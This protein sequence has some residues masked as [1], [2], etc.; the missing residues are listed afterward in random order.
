MLLN[1][2]SL[3]ENKNNWEEKNINLPKF[4]LEDVCKN[5]KENP[6]WLH[7]GSGNIFRGYVAD[8]CQDLLNENIINTGIVAVE[9]FDYE[10][11]E[12]TY[13][14]F[15]NLTLL[16]LMKSSGELEKKV[17]ASVCET[18]TTDCSTNDVERLKEIF[19]KENLQMVSFTI[20]EKA[21]AV[22]T[23]DGNFLEIVKSDIENKLASPKHSIS[24]LVS[25]LY[26]R[27]KANKLKLA[28]VS[29]DNCSNNGDKLKNSVLTVANELVNNGTLDKQFIDYLEDENYITFP[30]SMI[31]KI[32]PRPSEEV[33][34]S[35]EQDG[36][37]NVSP[38]KTSKNTFI[39]PFVNAEVAKY[40]VIEDKFPNGRPPLE[41][42]GVYMTNR[43]TVIKTETMKVTTCLN[44]LHT[45]LAIYGCVLSYNS[46][47][48]EMKD[49]EL[50]NL[51]KKMAYDEA[52]PVVVSPKILN[53]E[54]F[55][56]EVIEERLPNPFIPDAP[57]RI[58]TDTSQKVGIR[59]G[60]TLKAYVKNDNLNVE[61]LTY[62]PLVIAGWFR[63]LLAIDD[64]GNKFE[65]SQDPMLN[66]LTSALDGIKIGDKSSYK[67]NLR[68][69]LSNEKLFGVDFIKIGLADKI[70]NIFLELIEGK[71]SVRN[72]LKKYV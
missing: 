48:E 69:F 28:L 53:P 16:A 37:E 23:L 32:T 57:Q 13:R 26:E 31:D 19:R 40:L 55:V 44:P 54:D 1:Y 52:M 3:S 36:I 59:Y 51:I 45:A 29:M 6:T 25:M 33:A 34:K 38:I 7:F 8:L 5:T 20:T 64:N 11:I 63:Y 15:D 2:A 35:F 46:I 41:K 4:N 30:L 12:K 70:E 58:A 61:N 27:F 56:K 65:L 66:E 39:A 62:I 67:N 42:A 14:P 49:T 22:K 17:I 50:V 68:Q 47:A 60:E 9:S 21:Y 10:I 72:T 18:L 24:I 71:G 43:E